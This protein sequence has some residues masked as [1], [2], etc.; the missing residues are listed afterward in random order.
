MT[1]MRTPAGIT[2]LFT[3]VGGVL[4]TNGW[5]RALRHRTAAHFGVSETEMDERHHLTY[6]TYESGKMGL[7][8]YLDRVMFY[9]PRSFTYEDVVSFILGEARPFPE[10]IDLVRQ[11]KARHGLKVA[12]LSNEGRE[13]TA[14]RIERFGL[15]AFVDFFVV[16]S[17]VHFRKPDEDIFRVALDIAQARPDRVAYIDDRRMFVEVAAALGMHA[18]WHRAPATTRTALAALGLSV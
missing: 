17:Y 15:A 3:D 11:L 6:D 18:I 14:D 9:E 8:A 2:H 1:T 16:S 7:A 12:V 5:D 13:L 10:M 4:L